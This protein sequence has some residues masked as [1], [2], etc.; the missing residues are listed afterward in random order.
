MRKSIT[1]HPTEV[2]ACGRSAQEGFGRT[3]DVVN[4]AEQVRWMLTDA[5]NMV[6]EADSAADGLQYVGNIDV[7]HFARI[8][9]EMQ[10]RHA[11]KLSNRA[12]KMLTDEMLV[13]MLSNR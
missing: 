4:V 7:A 1:I 12:R 5:G 2:C 13:A 10:R 8:G 6:K 9:I 11:R 3:D